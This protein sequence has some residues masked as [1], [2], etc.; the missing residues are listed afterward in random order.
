[1]CGIV[2]AI[3]QRPV[4]EILLE[5]LRKLEYRGYDSAGVALLD[6][7]ST[8]QR[9]RALGK[10]VELE[11]KLK[12]EKQLGT[13]GISHTRWATHGE[14]AERN[15]HPH[16]SNK[17]VAVVHNGIIENYEILR[18]RLEAQGYQ[19]ESETDTEVVVH[20]IESNMLNGV[21]FLEATKKS[22][23]KLEGA[24]ALGVIS[25]EEPDVLITAVSYTHLTLPTIYSV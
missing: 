9:V 25:T 4:T 8:I 24:Y 16:V 10:V 20:L 21:S 3:A 15:A 18:D 6:G 7:G 13:I 14:P 23:K 11:N 2:G 5:G 1:M 12:N 17:R 22:L 19:F